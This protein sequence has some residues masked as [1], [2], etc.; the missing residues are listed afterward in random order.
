M[1]DCAGGGEAGV[2]V[3]ERSLCAAVYTALTLNREPGMKRRVWSVSPLP[4]P[5]PWSRPGR[6]RRGAR[7]EGA[8]YRPRR[9]GSGTSLTLTH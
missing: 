5:Q 8:P 1:E 9:A 6:R 4:A 3:P 2:P 7:A